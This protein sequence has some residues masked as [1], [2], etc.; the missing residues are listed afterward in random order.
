MQ[1]DKSDNLMRQSCKS[2]TETLTHWNSHDFRYLRKWRY[3]DDGWRIVAHTF[4]I[5]KLLIPSTSGMHSHCKKW[6]II[7]CAWIVLHFEYEHF[8]VRYSCLIALHF[9]MMAQYYFWS[10]QQ[11]IIRALR[12]CMALSDMLASPRR[13]GDTRSNTDNILR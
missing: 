1:T 6:L 7:K 2:K 5:E 9:I 8:F 13:C 3:Q 4:T 12:Q 11:L 10:K